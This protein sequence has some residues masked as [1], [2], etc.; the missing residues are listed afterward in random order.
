MSVSRPRRQRADRLFEIFDEPVE[1]GY[2]PATVGANGTWHTRT[3]W[4]AGEPAAEMPPITSGVGFEKVCFAYRDSERGE[5]EVLHDVDFRIP[6]GRALAL[7]GSSGAGKSTIA[8]LI[9]RFY[10]PTQGRVTI[11]G[12]D[13]RDIRLEGLRAQ[14]AMVT[15]ETILFNDSVRNN[16]AYCQ[17]GISA[18]AVERAARAAFAHEFITDLP[19]GYDTVVGERG[20]RLSGGQRQ[21]IAIARALLKDA[22]LLILDEATS[23]LDTRSDRLVQDALVNLLKGRTTLIIAHRMSTV[24]SADL[25]VVIDGG[26]VIESGNHEQLLARRGAYQRLYALHAG[27]PLERPLLREG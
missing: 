6:A 14:V 11:D 19:S 2:D 9:P 13:I 20:L 25:I 12:I 3:G 27:E 10:E 15:Q 26:R 16:I 8:N 5:R 22:A 1:S 17:P 18:A 24:R 23:N 7:V 4:S 21:R